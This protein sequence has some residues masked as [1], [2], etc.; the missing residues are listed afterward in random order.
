MIESSHQLSGDLRSSV[1]IKKVWKGNLKGY[2]LGLKLSCWMWYEL[3]LKGDSLIRWATCVH[4]YVVMG[5]PSQAKLFLETR[6]SVL[7]SGNATWNLAHQS[8]LYPFSLYLITMLTWHWPSNHE[9]CCITWGLKLF[10]GERT[11]LAKWGFPDPRHGRG[12][13]YSLHAQE[14]TWPGG[15]NSLQSPSGHESSPLIFQSY[16]SLFNKVAPEPE[17]RINLLN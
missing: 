13:K 17:I 1:V 2:I 8:P 14:P 4:L 9:T 15:F 11:N 10:G 6:L 3:V 5:Q 16:Y 7:I 12:P